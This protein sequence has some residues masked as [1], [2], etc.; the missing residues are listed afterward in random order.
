MATIND[1]KEQ[2]VPGT[3]LFLFDCTLRSGDIQRWS[4][5]KVVVNG[6]QYLS[7]ILK[8]NLFDLSSSP[9]A[10]TDAVS[11]VS[12]TLSNAD[13]FLSSI[14]RNI[15]WKGSQL[16]VSFMFFDLKNGV[17]ASDNE[18]V[19][20]GVANPPDQST[21]SA[22]RLSFTNRHTDASVTLFPMAHESAP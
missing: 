2:E 1:L 19:F 17:P 11:K 9:E 20:R 8:H 22:L 6:Q 13:S 7:R 16:T 21:E 15:G 10:T 5:H 3:P 14:E 12:I 18:V 4:T